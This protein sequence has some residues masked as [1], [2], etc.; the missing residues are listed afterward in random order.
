MTDVKANASKEGLYLVNYSYGSGST[1]GRVY[2]GGKGYQGCTAKVRTMCSSRYYAEDDM[3]N[4]FP[5]IM[6]QV[7]Q[8]TGCKSP[9]LTTYI[10]QREQLF[11]DFTNSSL[12]RKELK[13][14]FLIS[15]FLGDYLS[16]NDFT[17]IHFLSSFQREIRANA[18]S[19]LKN[20]LYA[21]IHAQ[22]VS[23]GKPNPLSSTISWVCQIEESKIMKAK[24]DFTERFFKTATNLFDGHL[25]ERG[26]L[27]M[28]ACSRYIKDTTGY[29]ATF[30]T[31]ATATPPPLSTSATGSSSAAGNPTASKTTPAAEAPAGQTGNVVTFKTNILT[32]SSCPV[33]TFT[34]ERLRFL[35]SSPTSPNSPTS[36]LITITGDG[37]C[38][39]R[40]A[41]E[42]C[43]HL[44]NPD[45]YLQAEPPVS[46]PT[47]SK[48]E[49]KQKQT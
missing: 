46:T 28:D 20:P 40:L 35:A 2:T 47:S 39:L 19:L 29:T 4:S 3:D 21:T 31:K 37:H 16:H 12:S 13:Q 34:P 44:A 17:P 33:P 9:C 38:V 10:N 11:Q 22:A 8:Q 36:T 45:H 26:T 30:T 18:R 23:Q 42:I 15:L 32:P 25:R 1:V 7:F 14:L 5:T 43:A 41:G 6:N 49:K 27:D 24:V 48:Q